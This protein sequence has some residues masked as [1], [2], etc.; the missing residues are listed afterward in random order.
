M[1]WR[2]EVQGKGEMLMT[3]HRRNVP[4]PTAPA[5]S[6]QIHDTIAHRYVEPSESRNK[7][8]A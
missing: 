4:L 7:E 1:I 5:L 6:G 8:A 2:V 3:K